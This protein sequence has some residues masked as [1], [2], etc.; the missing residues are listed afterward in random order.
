M[1]GKLDAVE[2]SPPCQQLLLMLLE[3]RQ[4]DRPMPAEA[5]AHP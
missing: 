4:E 5:L 3:T 2:A 1:L